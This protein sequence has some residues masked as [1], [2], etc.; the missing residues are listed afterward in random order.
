MSSGSADASRE[1]GAHFFEQVRSVLQGRPVEGDLPPDQRAMLDDLAAIRQFARDLSKGDLSGELGVKGPLAG[2][3]KALQANLRHLT[4]QV[5]Q[6]AQGDYSQ[7]VEFMGEFSAAFHEM[8]EGLRRARAEE[9]EQRILAEALRDTAAALNSAL[10]LDEVIDVILTNIGRVVPHDTL[11][12]YLVGEHNIA[13]VARCSGYDEISPGLKDAV[14]ALE[15]PVATTPNLRMMAETGRPCLVDDLSQFE[16]NHLIDDAWAHSYLGAPIRVEGKAVGFLSLLAARPGYFTPEQA[17]RLMAFANQAAVALQKVRLIES[18]HRL[19]TTDALTGLAN[20]RHF[21]EQ[22]EREF[23]HARRYFAPLSA[24]MLDIDHFKQVNDTY[25]HAAGDAVL[26][27]VAEV[28]AAALRKVDVIGRYG[29][30]EFAAL[31]P[32]TRLKDAAR[33]AERLALAV[34]DLPFD[35]QGRL[36]HVTVS[37]GVAEALGPGDTLARMI[38]R[39]DQAMYRA[40][41]AGRN[42][43][44]VFE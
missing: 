27:M 21:M 40:K 26:R 12:I 3:L 28:C 6:V 10:E 35:I 2:S 5:Q 22:A 41:Q 29:G 7:R 9:R 11:D 31:L 34:S 32:E 13:R 14:M 19:A 4:W 38:D 30:E 23:E 33:V 16:W 39:A 44:V 18:L 20:R 8:T 36:L 42:R 37:V 15:L 43:V 17:E 1:G 25:G 24:L